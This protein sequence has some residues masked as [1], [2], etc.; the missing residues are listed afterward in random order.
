MGDLNHYVMRGGVEGRERLRILSRVMH[1]TTTALFDRLGVADGL[2]CLDA[3]CGGGDVTRELAWWVGPAG[4]AVG[5][6]IEGNLCLMHSLNLGSSE[7]E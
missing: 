4:K 1:A 5:A 3:G 2:V 6:D 7:K